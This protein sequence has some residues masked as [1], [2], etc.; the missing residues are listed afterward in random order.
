MVRPGNQLTTIHGT[1]TLAGTGTLTA[2]GSA[3]APAVV[4]QWANTYG[5]G[6]TF[7]SITSSLQS[8]VVPLTPATPSAPARDTRRRGTGCS[9]SPRGRRTRR[10][11]TSTSAPGTTSTRWWREYPA[12]GSGGNT[13]TS[14]AY[15]PN[16]RPRCP[17][18]VYVAPDGEIAA[19]N[20]LVVEVAGARALGHRGRHRRRPTTRRPRRISLSLG[21]PGRRRRSS[22][23]RSAGTTCPP[24]RRSSRPGGRA[25]ATQTQTNG[26]NAPGRQHPHRRVPAVHARRPVGVRDGL[27]AEDLSGFLLAVYVT[28]TRPD[29]RRPEPG[30]AAHD[31]RGRVR[32]RVQHPRLGD[33]LD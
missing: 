9:P 33:H 16:T 21:A 11:P 30:L 18:N 8:C 5:Q 3:P 26:A 4:N 24:G 1:A 17:G 32:V 28:G 27:A 15:T 22:S 19:I 10:S 13:R 23:A 14:I 25:L 7:T 12:S 6:T 2:Y 31:V 29:P 20:V